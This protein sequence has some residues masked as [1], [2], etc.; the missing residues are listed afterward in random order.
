MSKFF[1]NCIQLYKCVIKI[2]KIVTDI[3]L[4]KLMD[5]VV[6]KACLYTCKLSP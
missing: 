4:I 2:L 5:W 3:L 1:I 6:G